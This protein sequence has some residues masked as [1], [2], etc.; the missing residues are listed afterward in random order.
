MENVNLVPFWGAQN[1]GSLGFFASETQLCYC[2]KA[3]TLEI[4]GKL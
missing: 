3:Y 1:P 2:Q 4:R